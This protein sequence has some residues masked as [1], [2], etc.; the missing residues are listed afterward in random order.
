MVRRNESAFFGQRV[1][2]LRAQVGAP[3]DVAE[4]AVTA[5]KEEWQTKERENFWKEATKACAPKLTR[6]VHRHCHPEN[7]MTKSPIRV[8]MIFMF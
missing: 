5:D 7:P 2:G 1:V 3:E 4:S 8:L 6:D